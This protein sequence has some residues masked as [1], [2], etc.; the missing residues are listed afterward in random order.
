MKIFAVLLIALFTLGCASVSRQSGTEESLTISAGSRQQLLDPLQ[1]ASAELRRAIAQEAEKRLQPAGQTGSEGTAG[2]QNTQTVLLQLLLSSRNQTL[3]PDAEFEQL[4]KVVSGENLPLQQSYAKALAD[5]L[6]QAYFGCQ[7]PVYA[8]YFQRRYAAANTAAP[9]ADEIPL[10]VANR[11]D[12]AKTVWLDPKRVSA[13]HLLFASKSSSMASRFGHIALRLVV[14]PAGKTTPAVCDANLFEHVVLGF[15]AHID[16]LSLD[17]LK[18]LNGEYK[19]YLFANHFMDV[20]EEYA[21]GEFRE[22]YSLPLRLDDAQRDLMVRE[23]ADIHWSYSGTYSFFTRNCATMTQDALRISWPQFATGGRTKERYLRPDSL[24]E[25]VKNSALAESEKLASL[26]AAEREGYF[27]SSTR[28]FYERALAEVRTAMKSPSFSDIDSYLQIHPL[29]RRQ[30]RS[31]DIAFSARLAADKHLREAQIML[32]EYAVLRSE[33]MMMIAGAKYFEEQDFLSRGDAIR[34]QLDA[35]HARVFDDCL[36]TPIRQQYAPIKRLSGIPDKTDI[37]AG[38]VQ[39]GLCQSRQSK[40]LLQEAITAIKNAKS[41]QWQ[42]LND[43]SRYWAESIASVNLL[44][45]L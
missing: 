26:D 7:H 41:A 22:V 6:T 5:Y 8:G 10:T 42:N 17:T 29:K 45:Q 16:E 9:C 28:Q 4:H 39:G 30:Q 33:R 18:A 20:Y 36:L 24:F 2:V 13:I 43:I 11:Y 44:K 34:A 3:L 12:G 21:I 1:G 27:F 19:A 35:E 37:P 31:E 23:L 15:R 38:P 40:Q 14:C 32:E 25:A